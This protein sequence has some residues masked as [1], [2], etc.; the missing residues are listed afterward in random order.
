MIESVFVA[1]RRRYVPLWGTRVA[2]F[3]RAALTEDVYILKIHGDCVD[4]SDRVLTR[5]EYDASYGAD[6]VSGP[7]AVRLINVFEKKS[8]LFLG[9][10]LGQD[11]VMKALHSVAGRSKATLHFAIC[12]AP[13]TP[14]ARRERSRWLHERNIVPIYYPAGEHDWVESILRELI[15]EWPLRAGGAKAPSQARSGDEDE[16]RQASSVAPSIAFASPSYATRSGFPGCARRAT[17]VCLRTTWRTIPI[18][19]SASRGGH[20]RS[21]SGVHFERSHA[22]ITPIEIRATPRLRLASSSSA[23]PSND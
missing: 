2:A 22:F 15:Q 17:A 11:R 1:A 13:A 21:Q 23:P 8:V 4:P 20:R 16:G 12:E 3:D 19:R 10:S 6:A 5:A 9:C 18:R 14:A 7:A